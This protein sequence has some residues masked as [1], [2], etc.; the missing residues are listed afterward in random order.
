MTLEGKWSDIASYISFYFPL[1]PHTYKNSVLLVRRTYAC[2]YS[3]NGSLMTECM[4][5]EY[6][7]YTITMCIVV[8]NNFSIFVYREELPLISYYYLSLV[9]NYLPNYLLLLLLI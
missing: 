8:F 7:G 9:S 2:K 5:E 4:N 1:L 6:L 3:I